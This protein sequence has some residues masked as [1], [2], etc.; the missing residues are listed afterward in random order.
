M[1]TRRAASSGVPKGREDLVNKAGCSSVQ[2]VIICACGQ[3]S[4][5]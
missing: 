4:E 2:L 5:S 3:T 1:M